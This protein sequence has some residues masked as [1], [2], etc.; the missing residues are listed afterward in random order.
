MITVFAGVNGDYIETHL[1]KPLEEA[2]PFVMIGDTIN[3]TVGSS[4]Q[5]MG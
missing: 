2:Y 3:M 5:F 1:A 4:G